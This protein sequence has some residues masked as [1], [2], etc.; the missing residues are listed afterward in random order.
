MVDLAQPDDIAGIAADAW[1]DDLLECRLDRHTFTQLDARIDERDGTYTRVRR[2]PRCLT[3]EHL[4]RSIR[5]GERVK[6][7]LDYSGTREG[8]LLPKGTG[9]MNA[10]AGA[11][12]WLE[13]FARMGAKQ[14][15]LK[16]VPRPAAPKRKTTP[17]R[18]RRRRVS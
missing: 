18:G 15:R 3:D 11:A 10:A 4:I 12:V 5:T 16:A 7:W 13:L 8:Y 1:D 6:R 9:R 17:I 2:C 14:P